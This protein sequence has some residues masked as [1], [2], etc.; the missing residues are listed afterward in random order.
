M[1]R[2]TRS[3]IVRAI[4]IAVAVTG[5]NWPEPTLGKPS[6]RGT[7]LTVEAGAQPSLLMQRSVDSARVRVV[8][9]TAIYRERGVGVHPST[10]EAITPGV[11]VDVWTTG[12][13]LRSRPVQ[14]FARQLIVK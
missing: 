11:A 7:V 3:S 14:Y 8:A 9:N 10:L 1:T 6:F 13:E 2:I 12:V 4:A 5:C